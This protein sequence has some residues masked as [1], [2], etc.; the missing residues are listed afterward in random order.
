ME[1][2]IKKLEY[3]RKYN[4]KERVHL[5]HNVNLKEMQQSINLQTLCCTHLF[6]G[7]WIAN[8]EYYSAKLQCHSKGWMFF[9]AG[10]KYLFILILFVKKNLQ[11]NNK[12]TPDKNLRDNMI[13]EGYHQ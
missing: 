10:G 12:N 9:R 7:F 5:I 1:K 13:K 4:L 2:R 11:R 8:L 6:L 3:I